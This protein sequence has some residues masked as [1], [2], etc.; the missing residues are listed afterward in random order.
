[1]KIA[2]SRIKSDV[3]LSGL[4]IYNCYDIDIL[5]GTEAQNQ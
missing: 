4:S 5:L 2:L 3:D 1:M